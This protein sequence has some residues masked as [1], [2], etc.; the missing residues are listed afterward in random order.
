MLC[1]LERQGH[2]QLPTHDLRPSPGWAAC[3]ERWVRRQTWQRPLETG[4]RL[5]EKLDFFVRGYPTEHVVAVRVAPKAINDGLMTKFETVVGRGREL[6]EKSL[7]LEVHE[8][9]LAMHVWHEQESTLQLIQFLK[10]S[11]GDRF[12]RESQCLRILSEGLW[13]IS[14]NIAGE[15]IEDDYFSQAAS[16]AGPPRKQLPGRGLLQELGISRPEQLVERGIDN[17]PISRLD[18]LEPERQNFIKHFGSPD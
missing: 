16:C 13:L 8:T 15:L 3:S 5:L 11:T 18:F 10:R 14:E 17:P 7:S 4:T 1:V 2:R 9:G 12:L 6:L